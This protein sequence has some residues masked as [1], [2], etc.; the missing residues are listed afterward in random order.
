MPETSEIEAVIK[1]VM[2]EM[3]S[4]G[5][6][7]TT[8]ADF[9]HRYNNFVIYCAENSIEKYTEIVGQ[10][11]LE[12]IRRTR[13]LRSK[14]GYRAFKRIIARLDYAIKGLPWKPC[15]K[16]LAPYTKSV[17][18]DI[19][20]MY[21]KYLRDKK[22]PDY[23]RRTHIVSRFLKQIEQN[24][25]SNLRNLDAKL[26]YSIFIGGTLNPDCFRRYIKPFLKY[27]HIY[28]FT[29][30]D[31]SLVCPVT[32][33][34]HTVPSV[35]TP[36]EVER[37]LASVDREAVNGKRDFAIMLIAARLGLRAGDI[38]KLKFENINFN[39]STIRIVQSKTKKQ[40]KLPM[41]DE[42]KNA[43]HDYI[44]TAKQN[45]QDK[46]VFHTRFGNKTISGGAVNILVHK[47]FTAAGIDSTSKRVGP[48]ALR[49][50]LATAL[51]NEGNDYA[52]VRDILGHSDIQV[53]K[54]Y[55]KTEIEKLRSCAIPT[56]PASGNFAA[57]LTKTVGRGT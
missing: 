15:E 28:D 18:D 1:I 8:V 24:N 9:K 46:Y 43:L 35:Y 37:A 48:H 13:N 14:D 47:A 34:K 4:L 51:L 55:V 25:C 49:A 6:S 39:D 17:F 30:G 10:Q 20:L 42:V 29:N 54:A 7:D 53:A 57:L 3:A 22:V 2:S 33:R 36:E 5:Y 21:E 50:S 38:V 45:E 16:P 12:Y 52:V 44:N 27:A 11:Y 26:I 32:K 56:P 23:Y 31:L 41:S 19:V 40:L